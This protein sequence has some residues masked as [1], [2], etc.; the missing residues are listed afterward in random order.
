M[1]IAMSTY[2][3]IPMSS[4]IALIG[5]VNLDINIQTT[6]PYRYHDSNIVSAN[7]N[8]GGVGGNIAQNLARLGH[9]ITLFTVF[10]ND[11]ISTSLRDSLESLSIDTSHSHILTEEGLNLYLSILDTNHDLLLGLNDMHA[12][13]QLTIS[14]LQQKHDVL[15]QFET[16][17]I[18]NNLEREVLEYII[19]TYHNKQLVMDAVSVDKATKLHGITSKLS[20]LKVNQM[21]Y[22][23]LGRDM[24]HTDHLE[25]LVSNGS[26]PITLIKGASRYSYSPLPCTTI[27]S[28]SGAGDALISGYLDAR[29]RGKDIPTSLAQAA[30]IAHLTLQS[31]TSTSIEVKPIG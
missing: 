16:I 11:P 30:H 7:Q 4:N 22:E 26:Q 20:I 29:L 14:Y 9:Q 18:D 27:I 31:T 6:K 17:I 23:V 13:K 15:Q 8:V 24:L 28:S 3:P 12:M 5:A 21:E 2:H 19:D 10:G 1:A 25:L